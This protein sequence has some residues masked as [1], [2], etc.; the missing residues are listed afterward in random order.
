MSAPDIRFKILCGQ[1]RA[2]PRSERY[3][4]LA[5]DAADA[6]EELLAALDA[7]AAAEREACAKVCD[8]LRSTFRVGGV[9][10]VRYGFAN[11][12]AD[13]IRARSKE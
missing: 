11:Q 13:A 12:C 4:P 6:V 5:N 1:L 2:L 7:C 3:S 9:V 8:A 10:Y